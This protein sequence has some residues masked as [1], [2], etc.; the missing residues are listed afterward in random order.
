MLNGTKG[1]SW[2]RNRTDRNKDT[3]VKVAMLTGVKQVEEKQDVRISFNLHD[4]SH[5]HNT[6]EGED[7]DKGENGR[8]KGLNMKIRCVSS[9]KTRL[10]RNWMQATR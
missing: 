4:K 2:F 10:S 3:T 7:V 5:N 9:W 6:T 1:F 8:R